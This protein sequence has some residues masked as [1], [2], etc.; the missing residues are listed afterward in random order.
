MGGC[1][2]RTGSADAVGDLRGQG[3]APHSGLATSKRRKRYAHPE[4]PGGGPLVPP[5][6]GP[7]WVVRRPYKTVCTPA[8]TV[9]APGAKEHRRSTGAAP[10]VARTVPTLV[11]TSAGKH[12][13]LQAGSNPVCASQRCLVTGNRRVRCARRAGM[14]MRCL[15][16]LKR[17]SRPNETGRVNSDRC[18]CGCTVGRSGA[19]LQRK[20]TARC[21]H[22]AI[23]GEARRRSRETRSS[24]PVAGSNSTAARHSYG[25]STRC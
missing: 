8:N 24:H 1:R 17:G 3:A 9:R 19:R 25:R 18:V 14:L 2:G 13:V 16:T 10:L 4:G 22:R 12:G 21:R 15:P 6:L 11:P 7:L 5:P 20:Q 23:A